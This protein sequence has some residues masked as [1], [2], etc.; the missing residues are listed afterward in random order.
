MITRESLVTSKNKSVELTLKGIQQKPLFQWVRLTDIYGDLWLLEDYCVIPNTLSV[1]AYS[2]AEL[3]I[4]LG[5]V[6]KEEMV[7][8]YKKTFF[9]PD[10]VAD[11]V[12]SKI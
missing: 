11:Y 12:M 3:I 8:I 10:A 7:E 2:V 1:P 4:M 9:E 6:S 5:E